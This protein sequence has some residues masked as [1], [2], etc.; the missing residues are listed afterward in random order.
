MSLWNR[1]SPWVF[2]M[3]SRNCYFEKGF[4]FVLFSKLSRDKQ[5]G[6][7]GSEFHS[8]ICRFHFCFLPNANHCEHCRKS[9]SQNLMGHQTCCHGISGTRFKCNVRV[10]TNDGTHISLRQ[11]RVVF[12]AKRDTKPMEAFRRHTGKKFGP[13]VCQFPGVPLETPVP[14]LS[15]LFWRWLADPPK[16]FSAGVQCFSKPYTIFGLSCSVGDTH[17]FRD[18]LCC[19][20]QLRWNAIVERKYNLCRRNFVSHILMRPSPSRNRRF[21]KERSDWGGFRRLHQDDATHPNNENEMIITHRWVAPWS[22]LRFTVTEYSHFSNFLQLLWQTEM[23]NFSPIT[24][25]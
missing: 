3:R 22:T 7:I 14:A 4:W 15:S 8:L 17:G 10:Q 11:R 16:H 2:G 19:I 1:S 9:T 5:S 25:N 6:D 24:R 20:S 13:T 21:L 23:R 18:C 12:C